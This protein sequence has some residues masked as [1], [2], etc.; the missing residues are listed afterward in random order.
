[1]PVAIFGAIALAIIAALSLLG[2]LIRRRCDYGEPSPPDRVARRI[3]RRVHRISGE[4]SL[5]RG[6]G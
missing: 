3:A 1:L 6:M 2:A 5:T 4:E